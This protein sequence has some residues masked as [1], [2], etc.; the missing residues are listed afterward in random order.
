MNFLVYLGFRNYDLPDATRDLAVK[1]KDLLLKDW[2]AN[3]FIH[4]NYNSETGE[5]ADVR[6]SD[7]FYHWGALLGIV[8]LIEEGILPPPE[9]P[10]KK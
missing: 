10:L 3:R 4:E 1:S 7:N 9:K 8:Y 2:Q 6:N 5:G